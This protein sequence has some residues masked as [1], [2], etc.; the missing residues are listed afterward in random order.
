MAATTQYAITAPLFLAVRRMPEALVAGTVDVTLE[1][2]GGDTSE[3][4]WRSPAGGGSLRLATL[5]AT[6]TSLAVTPDI[7]TGAQVTR[8]LT[9][10]LTGAL[11]R[12]WAPSVPPVAAGPAKRRLRIAA[13]VAAVIIP[14]LALA[15]ARVM[16]PPKPMDVAAAVTQFRSESAA[17]DSG[18]ARTAD[19]QSSD[20]G[21]RSQPASAAGRA[22]SRPRTAE[23]RR[24]TSD[25]VA[26]TAP[27]DDSSSPART[28]SSDGGTRRTA[29][30]S[31][32]TSQRN[33]SKRSLP[34]TP[35]EGVYRYATQGYESID[36]PSS[37]H[38]YPSETAMTIRHNDCG[39]FVAHWQ[40]L[41]NR[42]DEMTI[43]SNTAG[44]FIPT[45][46]THR[47]FYGQEKDSRYTC[48]DGYYA[49]RPQT[50]AT[51]TG[52][53][54]DEE[55]QMQV[56]GRTL[57]REAVRVGDQTVEAVH[58]VVEARIT[59]DN[60]GTWRA[61]RWVDPKTGLLVRARANTDATSKSSFGTVRYHEETDL[62]LL[63]MTPER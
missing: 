52:R 60:E 31:P 28:Q 11:E 23:D 26:Q 48:S 12:T 15:G 3:W 17:G 58:Y 8:D 35:Q 41:E 22:S 46:A 20:R 4:R 10:E 13:A 9:V 54:T 32:E 62:R 30:T 53:C 18:T 19:P 6:T 37:R 44:S 47:E 59:G 42:W 39:G 24:R 43:C 50:G 29:A 55:S 27:A 61:E 5:T 45:M 51:W 1:K 57:G 14:A 36:Q 40:P 16:A 33:T 7:G 56:Q 63:S 49:Y 34:P 2:A 38:D 25:T 21:G